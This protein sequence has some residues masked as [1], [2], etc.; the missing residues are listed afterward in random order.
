MTPIFCKVK[1]EAS[2]HYCEECKKSTPMGD[3]AQVEYYQ[4][5]MKGDGR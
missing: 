5:V 3:I 4:A 1:P 2:E